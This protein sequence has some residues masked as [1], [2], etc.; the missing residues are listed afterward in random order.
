MMKK[1][2]FICLAAGKNQIPLIYAA[3]DSGYKTIVID[4]N[5]KAPGMK[6]GDIAIQCSITDYKRIITKI[7]DINLH[8]QIAGIATRSFGQATISMI[9]LCN[10]YG[11]PGPGP[12]SASLFLNKRKLK[13]LLSE[14]GILVPKSY[15]WKTDLEKKELINS[16]LPIL[17][18][19][20]DGHGKTGLRLLHTK[21]DVQDFLENHP[22]DDESL[23]IE[24]IIKGHEYTVLGLVEN[25]RH[26]IISIT[27]KTT[28]SI[29]PLY[30]EL[31]HTW[32]SRISEQSRIQ[33]E[34]ILNKIVK[35]TNI[36]NSPFVSEF[37]VKK[38]SQTHKEEIFLVECSPETG[39][40]YLADFLLPKI[41]PDQNYFQNI[42]ALNSFYNDQ[43]ILENF[44]EPDSSQKVIIR[45]IPQKDGTIKNISINE[46][47]LNHSNVIFSQILKTPGDKTSLDGGN[48]DRLAVFAVSSNKLKKSDL[49][50]KVDS[51]AQ[52]IEIEYEN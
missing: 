1:N 21:F 24:S 47:I 6:L 29:K 25:G 33:I 19:P 15:A 36:K 38:N 42:I 9:S 31:Q 43:S 22:H 51:M 5:K 3:I 48:S 23:F 49:Q 44:S 2:H 16:R 13:G 28:S 8:D 46:K 12:L 26:K 52:D 30:I 14:H 40:E 7:S 37:L 17:V 20:C 39:G 41:Y 50:K 32:P 4:Q 10:H 35:I 34:A 27:D 18:R 11:T 45:F